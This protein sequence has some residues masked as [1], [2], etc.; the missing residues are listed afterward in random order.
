MSR[1]ASFSRDASAWA[2]KPLATWQTFNTLANL[3][4][5]PSGSNPVITKTNGIN[6][7]AL[8]LNGGTYYLYW[9][10]DS[11]V[12]ISLD[13]ATS[14]TGTW[15]AHGTQVSGAEWPS[16]ILDGS[17]WKMWAYASGDVFLFTASAPTGPWTAQGKAWTRPG[18]GAFSGGAGDPCVRKLADGTYMMTIIDATNPDPFYGAVGYLTSSTGANGSWTLA[19]N[20]ITDYAVPFEGSMHHSDPVILQASDGSLAVTYSIYPQGSTQ[21]GGMAI[22]DAAL[23][24]WVVRPTSL[25]SGQVAG[26]GGRPG[27]Y[28]FSA[29]VFT[30]A[31]ASYPTPGTQANGGLSIATAASGPAPWVQRTW[32]ATPAP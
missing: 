27:I 25:L 24:G 16:V 5:T 31:W 20:P 28:E 21:V 13:T 6:E 15:T 14:L 29:G 11:G 26:S 1:F 2:S 3:V 17:T 32:D 7:Y 4:F 23:G 12:N 9:S 19:R 22:F 18:S 30:L 10:D 8:V